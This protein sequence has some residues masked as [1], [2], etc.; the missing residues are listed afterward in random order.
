MV[1]ISIWFTIYL[2]E[3]YNQEQPNA[4]DPHHSI[5]EYQ[6]FKQLT[7]CQD[8]VEFNIDEF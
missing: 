5:N 2:R 1:K 4:I 8:L 6:M 3:I 7:F